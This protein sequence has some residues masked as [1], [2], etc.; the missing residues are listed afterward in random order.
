MLETEH[1]YTYTVF[2]R[3]HVKNITL[4]I[5]EDVLER[6]R[7]VAAEQ[8]TT[9]NA[10]VREFLANVADRDERLQKARE[11]LR[12]LMRNSKGRMRPDFKFNREETHER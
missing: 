7:L 6:A 1:S 9:V 2:R 10:M 11:G 12:E 8:K 5:D 4:A 3:P